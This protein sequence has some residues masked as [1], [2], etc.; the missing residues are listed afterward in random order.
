MSI[1]HDIPSH[2][3]VQCQPPLMSGRPQPRFR[4]RQG[5]LVSDKCRG[6]TL[7]A[8]D[9]K[10]DFTDYS[11]G[12]GSKRGKREKIPLGF[13]VHPRTKLTN[14]KVTTRIH[15]LFYRQSIWM[16]VPQC[17]LNRVESDGF[18]IPHAPPTRTER[19]TYIHTQK[20]EEKG[21]TI[22]YVLMHTCK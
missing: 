3:K 4:I 2:L 1:N 16:L 14:D 6:C 19:T 12:Q 21:A 18:G 15:L 13:T 22:Y 10:G 5:R 17:R 9:G 20:K 11:R 7:E 8:R